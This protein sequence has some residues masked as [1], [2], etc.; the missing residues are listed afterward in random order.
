MLSVSIRGTLVRDEQ[1]T[2]VDIVECATGVT[3]EQ[4]DFWKSSFS[5]ITFHDCHFEDC[6]FWMASLQGVGFDN[7]TFTD[8]GFWKAEL[9]FVS[10][11][12]CVVD[13]GFTKARLSNVIG[14]S[15]SQ[16]AQAEK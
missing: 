14:L 13:A 4:V 16:I 3:F 12:Q 10:F 11:R 15:A 6:S 9:N 1:I 7:C 8:C 5:K 2:G